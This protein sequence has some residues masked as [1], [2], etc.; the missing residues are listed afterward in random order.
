VSPWITLRITVT[1]PAYCSEIQGDTPITFKAPGMTQVK[2]MCWQQPT[3]DQTNPWGHDAEVAPGLKHDAEGNGSLVFHADQFPNGPLTIRLY[4][5]DDKNKQDIC[6]LQV[7]NKGGVVWNQGIPKNDPPAARNLKLVFADD[8]N[9]PLSIS[10]DGSNA[11]YAAHKSGGGD[12][13]GWQFSDPLGE[14]NPLGQ[15]GDFL[16][17]HAAKR[18]GTKGNSGI[19]SSIRADGTGVA[20]KP[21]CYFECRF[22]CQSAPGTWPAFWTLTKGTV[23]LDPNSPEAKELKQ[24]G[25]DEIDIIEAYGGYGVKN[26]NSGGLY[27]ATIHR[28]AQPKPEWWDQKNADSTANPKYIPHSYRVDTATLGGKS[29]WSWTFHTYGCLLTASDTVYYFDDI[30][31]GRH[32]TGPL[33]LSQPTW[34]LINYAIGGISGWKIDMDRYNNQSDMWVDFVRVYEGE[35]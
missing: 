7:Y 1:S 19:L 31:I 9:G 22:V 10:P 25:T 16:R 13:S 12:F 20:V 5:K 11:R 24:L 28:W 15:A 33:S 4:A 32:P 8:F 17:I 18:P 2:V 29:S 35:K 21:P 3:Q 6:E 30:E 27:S 26:P 14:N 34:F 23:G